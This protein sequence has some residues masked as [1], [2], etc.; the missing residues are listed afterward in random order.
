MDKIKKLLPKD[1]SVKTTAER[2]R[3]YF[4]KADPYLYS[5]ADFFNEHYFEAYG[6]DITSPF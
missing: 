1:S 2:T 3:T 5:E 6:I 4:K